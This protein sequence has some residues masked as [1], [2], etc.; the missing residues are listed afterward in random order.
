LRFDFK[1]NEIQYI[2]KQFRFP[3][4]I[5]V[6][7]RLLPTLGVEKKLKEKKYLDCNS[8]ERVELSTECRYLFSAWEKMRYSI[9]RADEEQKNRFFCVLANEKDIIL[10]DQVGA[11][12]VV[13]VIDFSVKVMDRILFNITGMDASK[14]CEDSFNISLPME[15]AT[16]FLTAKK[17]EYA[18]WSE[19]LGL[20]INELEAYFTAL[21]E[22]KH[23]VM[24][25]CEDHIDQRGAMIKI[26]NTEHGVYALK[27]VT[28]KDMTNEKMVLLKGNAQAIVDSIYIF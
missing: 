13:E 19:K 4:L 5:G 22:Q 9:V 16:K 18:L 28:P 24:C 8:S 15:E 1:L 2:Q 23:F 27:H 6:E 26:V 21:N 12:F 14:V 3:S 11:D 10:I 17:T 25:L 7:R 20:N